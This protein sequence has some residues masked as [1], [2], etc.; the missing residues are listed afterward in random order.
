MVDEITSERT[1]LLGIQSKETGVDLIAVKPV[2]DGY[3]TSS[4]II[5]LPGN[6]NWQITIATQTEGSPQ[7]AGLLVFGLGAL[8][9][10]LALAGL[11]Q[12]RLQAS[13]LQFGAQLTASEQ[14][15]TAREAAYRGLFE[16]ASTANVEVDLQSGQTIRANE[17]MQHLSGLPMDQIVGKPVIDLVDGQDQEM[18]SSALTSKLTS[19]AGLPGIELHLRRKDKDSIWVLASIGES[20]E[21]VSGEPSACIVMQ[22]INAR[23]K[24]DE[25]RDL[26]VRELAHRVRNTMQLIGSLADQTAR[27]SR[28]VPSFVTNFKGRLLALNSAQD[29]LFDANWGPVRVDMLVPKILEPFETE[30]AKQTIRYEIENLTLLPQEAQTIALALH[31]L[32][33]NA[34]RHGALSSPRGS[35][36][37]TIKLDSAGGSNR[38]LRLNWVERGGQQPVSAPETNGFGSIMLERLLA[39]QHGGESRFDWDPKGLKFEAILP[40]ANQEDVETGKKY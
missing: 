22:D 31:E 17:A 25:A 8:L 14:S 27:S 38:V 11:Q 21:A 5:G 2:P 9:T 29:A 7:A 18:L 24:A 4:R 10:L 12:S 32:A 15:L 1:V 36:D 34:S 37:L 19:T 28:D 3:T 33:N 6:S 26:L 30:G 40:L 35:V 13:N 23:K 39:R 20:S 16:N